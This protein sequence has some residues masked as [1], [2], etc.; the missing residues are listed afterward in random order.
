MTVLVASPPNRR[1][2]GTES[3][4]SKVILSNA[5]TDLG[6]PLGAAPGPLVRALAKNR[7][8]GRG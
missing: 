1:A 3:L 8:N 7:P 5:L 4:S 6:P 2:R